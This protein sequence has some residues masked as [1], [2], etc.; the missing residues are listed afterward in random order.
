M[1]SLTL[2]IGFLLLFEGVM[3]LAVAAADSLPARG[4]VLV[5]G[6][7]TT[8]LGVLLIVEWPNDSFRVI[9]TL[10]GVSLAMSAINLLSLPPPQE[11]S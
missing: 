6:I 5:D 3:E 7:V 2:F 8:V 4:L 9:G 1:I 10:L 11:A